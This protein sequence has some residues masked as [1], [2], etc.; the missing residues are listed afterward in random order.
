VTFPHLSPEQVREL[1]VAG[2][3]Y[4]SYPTVPEWRDMTSADASRALAVA[5]AAGQPCSLYVHIPFCREMC[6]YCGCHVIIARDRHKMDDYLALVRR[7]AELQRR[8]LGLRAPI[9]RLHLGGGTPTTLDEG[10]LAE[11]HAILTENFAIAPDA[12]LAL[13]ID[14]A[15][16]TRGQLTLLARLGFRRLSMGVQDLDPDV[17]RAVNRIQTEEQTRDALETARQAGFTSVNFD[18]I[19]GLPRQTPTSWQRTTE[20]VAALRPD[21]ISLFSFAYVPTVKPHQRRLAV[22]DMPLA[23]A[24]LELFR[25]GYQGFVAGGYVPIGMDHFALPEDELARARA[26]GRLWRD[27]QGYSAGRGGAGTIA[28]GVSAIG[29]VGGAYL[30]N[31]KTLPRYASAL[32]RGELPI[33]RGWLRSADDDE[34]RAIIGGLMCNFTVALDED[35]RAR[36]RPELERLGEL[37]KAD[38]CTVEGGRIT[39]TSTG[40]VFVRNVAMVFDA[41]LDSG[42]TAAGAFSRTV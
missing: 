41:Y 3:R 4:T 40:R 37:A 17:Q 22:V 33:A 1:D 14:P 13:E 34:R 31:V 24:K 36:Y 10:Q 35:Q 18:L 27:F 39:L 7:E 23:D 5:G 11:L 38:L 20:R 8:A 12:E 6:S 16:T 2:P 42:S 25:I 26:A 15:I 29:D 9:S 28:L 21:R 19:Y 30:Q 32:A